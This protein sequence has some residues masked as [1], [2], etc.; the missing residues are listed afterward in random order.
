MGEDR[1]GHRDEPYDGA[2]RV[3]SG[4]SASP[5]YSKARHVFVGKGAQMRALRIERGDETFEAARAR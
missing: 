5:T 4:P 1:T 3:E 2:I